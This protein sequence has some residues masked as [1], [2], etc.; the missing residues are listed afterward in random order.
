MKIK[1][2]F[3]KN[4]YALSSFA[5]LALLSIIYGRFDDPVLFA[6]R[7]LVCVSSA[8][9]FSFSAKTDDNIYLNSFAFLSITS[10]N[11]IFLTGDVHILL[12]LSFFMLSLAFSKKFRFITP[13]FSVLCVLAQ[14]LSILL[15][16][17]SVVG[18]LLTAKQ[19]ISALL[20]TLGSIGAFIVT[21]L[22][23]ENDFYVD[24]FSTYPLAV[25]LVHFSNTHLKVLGEYAVASIPL[26]AIL[27]FFVASLTLKKKFVA[28]VSIVVS[29]VLSLWGFA[30][31]E[32]YHA[33]VFTLAS[34]AMT[35]AMLGA[36]DRDEDSVFNRFNLFCKNHTLLF[37][38][39][40]VF[41]AGFPLIFGQI[42]FESDLFSR[43][44]FIIFRQE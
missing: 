18:Y 11:L 13:I 14:P 2:L 27:L 17:P 12:S 42:P 24:Q 32:N 19:K 43:I 23:A 22:L 37:L 26:I 20:S 36:E 31:S 30:M 29:F 16:V 21:K 1:A 35:L 41:V 6:L 9:F 28:S 38:L 34:A 10:C 39:A 8:L 44:A 40:V 4:K 5:V 3:S 7:L 33:V 25:H 15:L